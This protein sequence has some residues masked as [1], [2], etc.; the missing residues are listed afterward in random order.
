VP[1]EP[2]DPVLPDVVPPP[3]RA[4]FEPPPPPEV[5]PVPEVPDVAPVAAVVAAVAVVVGRVTAPYGL[6]R[7]IPPTPLVVAV[8]CAAAGGTNAPKSG[9]TKINDLRIRL[10][11]PPPVSHQCCGAERAQ[12]R[13]P[14]KRPN[15]ITR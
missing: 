9:N 11:T 4:A 7:V 3:V 15:N 8:V 2:A 10:T 6:A 14:L 5:D 13:L 1:D 12:Q